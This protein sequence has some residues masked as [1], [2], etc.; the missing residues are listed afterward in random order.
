MLELITPVIRTYN[1]APNI[2]RTLDRL[3]WAKQIIIVD[4]GSTDDTI[5]LV[6]RYPAVKVFTG[7]FENFAAQCNFGLQKVSTPWAL[8]LDAD[9]ELSE[10]L[11]AELQHLSP[12]EN[13]S[14]YCASFVYRV[15]GRNLRGTL[16]PP[17]IVLYR[18][19]RA[20]Y[21]DEGHTQRVQV[22]GLVLPLNGVIYHDDRKPLSRW[23]TS[24]RKYAT[25]EA[26]YLLQCDGKNLPT[27]DRIRLL[28]W[29]A[30]ILVFFYTLVWKRCI[31]DGWAGWYYVLQRTFAEICLTLEL[32]DRHLQRTP[33]ERPVK[34]D[35]NE[36]IV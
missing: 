35:S 15:Y 25:V 9:Y 16:Y 36:V 19:K 5:A 7:A 20:M 10:H 14:G 8:S 24:Q 13:N 29:P 23:I 28:L 12:E 30:P 26:D 17:R 21:H 33:T 1:E 32:I 4:S 11:I 31:L 27:V 3:A 34:G 18:P 2:R 6:S 22:S